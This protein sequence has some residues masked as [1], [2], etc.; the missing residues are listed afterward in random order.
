MYIHIHLW[1]SRVKSI[2][3]PSDNKLLATSIPS[4]KVSKSPYGLKIPEYSRRL[5]LPE[6]MTF[7]S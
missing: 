6:F 7:G 5:R 1:Y 3:L 2:V 4:K